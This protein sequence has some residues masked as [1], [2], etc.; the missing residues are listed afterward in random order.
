MK[1]LQKRYTHTR[2][3]AGARA[4]THARSHMHCPSSASIIDVWHAAF[5]LSHLLST[6]P[7]GAPFASRLP[8]LWQAG[9]SRAMLSYQSVSAS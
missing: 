9:I 7:L 2:M 4:H 5:P 8:P 3:Q 6:L 1:N